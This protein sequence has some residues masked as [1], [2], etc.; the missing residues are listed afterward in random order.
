MDLS[1]FIQKECEFEPIKEHLDFA[2]EHN[3]PVM[4]AEST[5]HR[6]EISETTCSLDVHKYVSRTPEAIWEKW[7][8]PYFDLIYSNSDV[9]HSMTHINARWDDQQIW[10]SP[11]YSGYWGDS[12]VQ[13]KEEILEQWQAELAKDLWL[14]G[15]GDLSEILGS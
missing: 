15:D 7:F 5:P 2:R 10:G 8:V 3:K 14:H 13:A 11:Y 6:Y 9:I 12:R 4:I 1:Y